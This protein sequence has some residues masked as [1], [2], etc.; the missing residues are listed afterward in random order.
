MVYQNTYIKQIIFFII[1]YKIVLNSTK[2]KN[3]VLNYFF[4]FSFL[5]YYY[6]LFAFQYTSKSLFNANYFISSKNYSPCCK[7]SF[8]NKLLS[9]F[10]RLTGVSISFIFPNSKTNILSY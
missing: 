6:F 1:I 8:L 2:N 7:T 9:F 5:S 4:I 3:N 10:N